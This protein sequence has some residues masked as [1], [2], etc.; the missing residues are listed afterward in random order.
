MLSAG[1]VVIGKPQLNRDA[2]PLFFLEAVGI[3]AGEGFDQ[4]GF[5]VVD[6]AGGTQYDFF[7]WIFADGE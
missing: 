4:G 2:P 6:M 5:S 3:D 1:Q 7:G